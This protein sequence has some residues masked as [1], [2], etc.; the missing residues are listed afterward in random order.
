[1]QLQLVLHQDYSDRIQTDLKRLR[2]P[3]PSSTWRRTWIIFSRF[4][5]REPPLVGGL[6]FSTTIQ[7]K[8]TSTTSWSQGGVEGEGATTRREAP[9]LD[10]HSQPVDYS[11]SFSGNHPGLTITSMPQGCFV[12]WK[13]LK[14]SELLEYDSC[15]VAESTLQRID[16]REPEVFDYSAQ[17]HLVS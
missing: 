1:M 16:P 9:V 7:N 13:G 3:S 17:L 6:P 8:T 5:T 10:K 4:E 12:Y 2:Y 14:P 11:E 15:L